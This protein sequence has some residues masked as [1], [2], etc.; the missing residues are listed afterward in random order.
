MS[1][2]KIVLYTR[3]RKGILRTKSFLKIGVTA[4]TKRGPAV[5]SSST[6]SHA[7]AA[8]IWSEIFTIV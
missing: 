8:A 5:L 4:A 2:I 3:E 1:K 6:V 7:A